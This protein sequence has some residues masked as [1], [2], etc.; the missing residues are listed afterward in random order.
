MFLE[1]PRQRKF[2]ETMSHHVFG[3]KNRVEYFAVMHVKSV[4]HEFG[5]NHRAARLCLDR[6]L[7]AG[8]VQ[9][10]YLFQQMAF[11]KRAFFNRTSHKLLLV[12]HWT[13]IAPHQNESV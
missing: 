1:C 4:A 11:D 10:R 7:R 5:R 3:H 9:L 13:A 12:F 2:A 8:R 6:L